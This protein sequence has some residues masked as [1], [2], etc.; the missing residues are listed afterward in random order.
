METTLWT[1]ISNFITK[2]NKTYSRYLS[3]NQK[4]VTLMAKIKRA[5]N[6]SKNNISWEL[7]AK[8]Y[9]TR[10]QKTMVKRIYISISK[11]ASSSASK[12]WLSSFNQLKI[13]RMETHIL[14]LVSEA[15]K[16]QMVRI[17]Q[18]QRIVRYIKG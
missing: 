16:T 11:I 18:E 1:I 10:Q 4:K 17:I 14:S 7:L 8:C 9:I 5:I 15:I 3:R 6:S 12:H 2:T 13:W